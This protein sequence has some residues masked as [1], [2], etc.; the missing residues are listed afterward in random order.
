MKSY[1]AIVIG[2]GP[3]G[4]AAALYLVRSGVKTVLV[5]KLSP[6]GQ[7][8][9]TEELEN[10][11]GFPRGIKGYELCDRM[12]EHLREYDLDRILDEVKEIKIEEGRH[13]LLVGDEW[14]AGRAVIFASGVTF[15]KLHVHNEDKL[16]GRG[17]SYCAICDGNFFRDKV[18]A[19]VGGGNSAL[20]E[21]LY[22]SRLVKKIYLIHR[23]E[24]FRGLKCY[25]DKCYK[26]PKIEMVLNS[27]VTR[28]LGDDDVSGVEVQ[29][30][31][32]EEYSEINLDGVF[33]FVGF[34]PVNNFFPPELELDAWGFIKTDQ[35][36]ATN[37]PGIYAAGDIRSKKCRQVVTAVGDGAT[38]ATA[39]FAYL[40]HNNG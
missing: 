10:Y 32:T 2:G 9:M 39:A 12:D 3:A 29:N 28:V 1:D 37:I 20:E 27:V 13:S 36:M 16:L 33:I 6:G 38:A 7:M 19:V 22:L 21:A 26:D 30:V 24:E 25:Q 18:I 17:V 11:P 40:E 35:E 14:I 34:D 15:R 23:R 8:L 31:K 5:E 4:M